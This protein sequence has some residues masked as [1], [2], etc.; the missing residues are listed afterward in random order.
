MHLH[1]TCLISP[2]QKCFV[3]NIAAGDKLWAKGDFLSA[4][5]ILEAFGLLP[6][7]ILQHAQCTKCG[8]SHDI[9]IKTSNPLRLCDDEVSQCVVH[10]AEM[11]PGRSGCM[12]DVGKAM[13]D[14]LLPTDPQPKEVRYGRTCGA[15]RGGKCCNAR[16]TTS[17]KPWLDANNL[18]E[19]R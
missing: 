7:V 4:E 12:V 19:V 6:P 16:F 11:A 15:L 3:N 10:T 13:R 17:G 2:N 5:R 8:S 1:A 14:H 9:A 18:R